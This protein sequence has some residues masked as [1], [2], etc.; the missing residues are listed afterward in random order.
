[1][2]VKSRSVLGYRSEDGLSNFHCFSVFAT[3]LM[4]VFSSWTIDFNYPDCI[5]FWI[6]YISM[7]RVIPIFVNKT[8]KKSILQ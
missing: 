3:F 2:S 4:K 6:C 5:M 1:M 8:V 7:G